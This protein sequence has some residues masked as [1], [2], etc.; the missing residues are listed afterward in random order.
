M[1][2]KAE[3]VL[4]KGFAPQIETTD[5]DGFSVS[6]LYVAAKAGHGKIVESLLKHKA[7]VD[8]ERKDGRTLLYIAAFKGQT[9]TAKLLLDSKAA[10]DKGRC[11]WHNTAFDSGKARPYG[12]SKAVARSK[13]GHQQKIQAVWKNTA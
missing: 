2:K 9:E 6:L 5:S 12:H 7:M 11:R 8:S 3:R 4:E 10:V 1:E 13:G